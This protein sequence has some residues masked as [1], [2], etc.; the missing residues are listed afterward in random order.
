MAGRGNAAAWV[1]RG[2]NDEF[3][4][5]AP[6]PTSGDMVFMAKYEEVEDNITINGESYSYGD[7]VSCK[8]IVAGMDNFSYF[9]R[10][11]GENEPEIIS[12]DADYSFSAYTDCTIAA[13]CNGAVTLTTPRKISLSTFSVGDKLTAVMAEFIGFDD[14]KEKGIMF[15]GKKIAMTTD[16]AQFTVTNDTNDDVVVKGYAIVGDD[17]YVDGKITVDAAK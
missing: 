14:A 17:K 15:G 7:I 5:G 2:T 1:Q 8:D 9:T 13:V 4:G 12:L 10:Q 16:K 6:A 11:I 3:D